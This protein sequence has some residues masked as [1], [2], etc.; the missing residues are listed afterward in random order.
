M[1]SKRKD[2]SDI[3]C[4][5]P[6][7]F[8]L[9]LFTFGAF[10]RCF[11][12][13]GGSSSKSS[14]SST[15]KDNSSIVEDTGIN[16]TDGA[17]ALRDRATGVEGNSNQIDQK[18][19]AGDADIVE[20]GRDLEI[21]DGNTF[22]SSDPDVAKA[23]IE[24]AEGVTSDAF[25]FATATVQESIGLS[26][27]SQDSITDT[28]N[29]LIQFSQITQKEAN[30]LTRATNDTL[31]TKSSDADSAVSATLQKNILIALA[32]VGTVFALRDR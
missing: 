4:L 30:D 14:Q 21:G 22:S 9:D 29:E 12:F 6:G 1:F 19:I 25:D 11:L 2:Q 5:L 7:S 26:S 17:K 28:F 13:G 18:E 10:T 27:K 24:G 32:I 23:A 31:A 15:Q 20:I 16:A 8:I 3:N